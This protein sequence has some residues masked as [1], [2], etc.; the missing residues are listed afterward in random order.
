MSKLAGLIVGGWIG[1]NEDVNLN[2]GGWG[3]PADRLLS[4]LGDGRTSKGRAHDMIGTCSAI[5]EEPVV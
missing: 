1:A 2:E 3:A 5:P 4:D